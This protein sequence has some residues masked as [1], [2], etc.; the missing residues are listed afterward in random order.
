[1]TLLTSTTTS[2]EPSRH[3]GSPMGDPG[4]A[5]RRLSWKK[6]VLFTGLT[7]FVSICLLGIGLEVVLRLIAPQPLLPRYVTDSGFGIRTHCP[8]IA[9][10]HTT[11]DY[12]I[13]I[14]TNNRGIRADHEFAVPKPGGT[15][16]IVGVGDSFTFGYGVE[17]EDTY[18]ARLE[19]ILAEQGITAEVVNLGVAGHGTAE[20]LLMLENVGFSL[21]PDLVIVGYY[22]NDIADTVR[23]SLYALNEDGTLKRRARAYLPG[24]EI[25]DFLYSFAL[26]RFLAERSHV[27]Y[28]V[29][30][31]LSDLLQRRLR[32]QARTAAS[33]DTHDEERLT[34]ALLDEI[35]RK[36]QDC[37][38]GFTILDIPS[39]FNKSN[40]PRTFLHV[41]TP[42]DIVDL[43]PTFDERMK[44]TKLYWTQSDGHWTPTGHEIAAD[45][46]ARRIAPTLS[47]ILQD[48]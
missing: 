30:T 45:A 25:R 13:A 24:V 48:R 16:R 17:V 47:Q 12:R 8:D 26:Y 39:E 9:I 42:D 31:R 11:A 1:M 41:V 20:Q 28:F 27:L 34:A 23:S 15:V 32:D 18:L 37:G 38:I 5:R 6:R 33:L 44:T 40:L 10:H 3:A 21:D 35:K 36:C 46:L 29:R 7:L 43:R 22:T 4:G 19:R 14:R 2:R